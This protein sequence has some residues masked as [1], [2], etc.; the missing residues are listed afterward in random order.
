MENGPIGYQEYSK[1]YN[2]T[3]KNNSLKNAQS[4]ENKVALL[5]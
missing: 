5:W 1:L 3:C 2:T 4:I